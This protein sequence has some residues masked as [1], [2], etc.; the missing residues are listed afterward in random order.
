ME[1][2]AKIRCLFNRIPNFNFMFDEAVNFK[3]VKR[4]M[5]IEHIVESPW[6]Y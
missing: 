6:T 1:L 5:I 2:L 3:N 4:S